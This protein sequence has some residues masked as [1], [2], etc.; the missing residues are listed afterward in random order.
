MHKKNATEVRYSQSLIFVKFDA[1]LVQ[2]TN[3]V[4]PG[5]FYKR[6]HG[7][8]VQSQEPVLLTQM[9][10]FLRHPISKIISNSHDWFKSYPN[11]K[12]QIILANILPPWLL[13]LLDKQQ[14]RHVELPHVYC[15]ESP[16]SSNGNE[17][18]NRL[19]A[20]GMEQRT[21]DRVQ[22]DRVERRKNTCNS[23]IHTAVI[24]THLKAMLGPS[25]LL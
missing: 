6:R 8:T 4:Q 2:L 18:I 21:R 3:P 19:Q 13:L 12:K 1:S 5:L 9:N 10:L 25:S 7:K 20:S 24:E 15:R 14:R 23:C 17:G 22:R 16:L 11:V